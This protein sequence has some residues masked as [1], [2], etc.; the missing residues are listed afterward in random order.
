MWWGGIEPG[1]QSEATGTSAAGFWSSEPRRRRVRAA[2][3]AGD[4][5]GHATGQTEDD[6][7]H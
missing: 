6:G 3:H 5:C 2:A 7:E 4:R 1:D